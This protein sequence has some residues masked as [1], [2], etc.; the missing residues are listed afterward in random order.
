MIYI[1]MINTLLIDDES[2]GLEDLKEAVQKYCPEISLQG[3]YP[4]PSESLTAIP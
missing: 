1:F 3:V 2:D 4:T